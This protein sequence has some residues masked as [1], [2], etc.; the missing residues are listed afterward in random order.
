MF[1]DV[2]W[3]GVAGVIVGNVFGGGSV[4]HIEVSGMLASRKQS[5][6]PARQTMESTSS[7]QIPS[8]F[9]RGLRVDGVG[10]GG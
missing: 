1:I 4:D 10:D 2:G 8:S 7:M 5:R 6:F 3:Q 9:M